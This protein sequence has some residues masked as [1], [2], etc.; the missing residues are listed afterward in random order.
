MIEP[1]AVAELAR[2]HDEA[3]VADLRELLEAQRA[4][5]TGAEMQQAADKFHVRVMEL[6]G[7]STLSEYAKLIHH[8]IRGH[9]RR[10]E[11][12]RRQDE[13]PLGH[14]ESGAHERL[15]ELI[16]AGAS[17]AASQ[18]WRQHLESVRDQLA[19]NCPMDSALDQKD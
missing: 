15:I 18:H 9:V 5:S 7:N 17:H 4:A 12:M 1:A 10:Y 13:P 6:A 3:A 11:S 8:L 19:Q 14:G 16:E 2:S